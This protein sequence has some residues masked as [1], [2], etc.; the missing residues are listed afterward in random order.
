MPCKHMHI[1]LWAHFLNIFS[2]AVTENE[3][4]EK[5][6]SK[7]RPQSLKERAKPTHLSVKIDGFLFSL[8]RISIS[9]RILN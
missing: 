8:A 7:G 1:L 5:E 6:S 2:I 9:F 3:V 4:A